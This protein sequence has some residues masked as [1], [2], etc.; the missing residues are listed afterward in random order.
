MSR[1]TITD[2]DGRVIGWF[3]PTT[4]TEYPEAKEWDGNNHISL[5]TGSQY[6]HE[7]LIRTKGGRWVLSYWSAYQGRRG[8]FRF[9]EDSDAREW[10]LRNEYDSEQVAEATGQPVEDERGP[11][12]PEIGPMVNVR[13]PPELLAMVDAAAAKHGMS[14]AAW[15]RDAAATALPGSLLTTL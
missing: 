3:D 10:L 4:T 11:G 6:D 13:F 14:R 1:T 2:D 12:R 7:S 15:L 5:A 8:G 9:V